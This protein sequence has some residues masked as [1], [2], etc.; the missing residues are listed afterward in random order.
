[1]DHSRFD[2]PGTD[3]QGFVRLMNLEKETP[4]EKL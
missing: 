1:M 4:Q 2:V 3:E